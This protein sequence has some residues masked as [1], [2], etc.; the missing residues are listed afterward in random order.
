MSNE[1]KLKNPIELA[2]VGD[3]VYEILVREHIAK[4]VD[5]N[6]GALHRIAVSYVCAAA[7]ADA[8]ERIDP[9]LT[10]EEKDIVR[11]GKNSSKTAVPRNGN[12]KSYRSATALEALF[13]YLFLLDRKE[14]ISELFSAAISVDNTSIA[15]LKAG[16]SE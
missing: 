16:I 8:L 10:E 2:F 3:A 13:G 9:M 15:D 12:P 4:C 11:R 6:A 14:R 7:Q 1:V 5:T